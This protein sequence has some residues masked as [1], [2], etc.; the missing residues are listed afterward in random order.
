MSRYLWFSIVLTVVVAGFTLFLYDFGRD[1][2]PEKVPVHWNIEGKADD[3]V[4][5]ERV[6]PYLLIAPGVMALMVLLTLALPWLSP[7]Q[8]SIERFRA[9]YDYI[10]ALIVG[11]FGYVQITLLLASI[12]SPV[13]TTRLLVG[14]IFLFFAALGNVLGKVRRNFYVGIRTPWTIASEQVWNQTH[15]VAA[16]LYVPVGLI[17]FL[18][19]LLGVKLIV[20]FVVFMIG[21]LFPIP[22]SLYLYKRLEREGK[23][24][25]PAG[26]MS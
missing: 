15:R 21:V 9:T 23:L 25:S 17:G 22:Y 3:Y 12:E 20:V 4:P 16:W 6:L 7:K 26:S 2:M 24:N 14:G 1:Y 13:D 10:M 19:V 11:L 5:R 18:A 8:F